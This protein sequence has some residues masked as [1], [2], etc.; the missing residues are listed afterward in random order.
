MLKLL[1]LLLLG[2]CAT[3]ASASAA[4]FD[5][6]KA[7]TSDERAV[8][9]DPALSERD[10]RMGAL[11]YSYARMPFLMGASGARKDEAQA[12]RDARKACGADRS[13]L[14]TAYDQRIAALESCIAQALTALGQEVNDT[15]PAAPDL[16]APVQA[17]VAGYAAQ[18]AQLGGKLASAATQPHILTGDLDGDG[19]PDYLL[20]SAPVRC[21]A[22]AT[23]F[24]GNGGCQID[25]VLSRQGYAQPVKLLG[26]Q[27]TLTQGAERLEALVWVGKDN[28]ATAPADGQACWTRL[29]WQDGKLARTSSL[30]PML[31]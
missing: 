22:A 4:S 14:I 28:C 25:L 30:G 27:P 9:A 8:C 31:P 2:A 17:V 11:W 20:D 13:C 1:S 12:F 21:D 3:L 24:C 16:P 7:R 5:C 23:A 19:Q 29:S 26:G 18:C 10:T 15:Q 6:R